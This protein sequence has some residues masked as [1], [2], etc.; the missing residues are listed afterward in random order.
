MKKI[1]VLSMVLLLFASC[2]TH[3]V[4]GP[5]DLNNGL[6][7]DPEI[8]TGVL[9]NGLRYVIRENKNPEQ[10][11]EF[12]FG[13]NSGSLMEEDDEKGIAHFIEHMAFNGTR[14]FSQKEMFDFFQ[15]NGMSF[16][17]DF[18]A[19]TTHTRIVYKFPLP[20]DQKKTID[21]G[22]L[23]LKDWADGIRFEK[24]EVD[25]ERNIILEELRARKN[26]NQRIMD[27][28]MP[29]VYGV[30]YLKS[31]PIG[32]ESVIKTV[33]HQKLK[34][35]YKK[36]YQ[37]QRMVVVVVGDINA[38]V[39]E[40]RIKSTFSGLKNN[41]DLPGL[42]DFDVPEYDTFQY[43]T[44]SDP[45]LTE[46][47]IRIYQHINTRKLFTE[48]DLRQYLIEQIYS[49]ILKN[50][51]LDKSLSNSSYERILYSQDWLKKYDGVFYLAATVKDNQFKACFE[52]IF[53]EYERM[54]RY[55]VF[56]SEVKEAKKNLLDSSKTGDIEQ[57]TKKSE[58]F[59]NQYVSK[60]MDESIMF[61]PKEYIRLCKKYL[62]SIKD[63]D[64][65][66]FLNRIDPNNR[67]IVCQGNNLFINFFPNKKDMDALFAKVSSM[68]V[69]LYSHQRAKEGLP[70]QQL[71]KSKIVN[72]KYYEK[73]NVTRLE[74][75]NGAKVVLKPTLFKQDDVVFR[76]YSP[77]CL[78][79]LDLK[80]LPLMELADPIFKQ[81]GLG[82]L[83]KLELYS[84]L[85][86]KKV[87][88]SIYVDIHEE[89]ISGYFS[90]ANLEFFF[91]LI[92]LGL[93]QPRVE[94]SAFE[95]QKLKYIQ[96]KQKM[97]NTAFWKFREKILQTAWP[98]N[99]YNHIIGAE[100]IQKLEFISSKQ[101][102]KDRFQNAGDFTFQFVG[103]FKMHDIL[104]LI[105]KHL[106]GLP[107]DKIK[108]K[109]KNINCKPLPGKFSISMNENIEEKSNIFIF[110]NHYYT[111][112][113][114]KLFEFSALE[115]ILNMKINESLREDQSLIYTSKAWSRF[116][117]LKPSPHCVIGF[118][119][120]CAPENAEKVVSGVKTIL[121]DLRENR[122]SEEKIT[123]IKRIQATK[124]REARQDNNWW[125]SAL[126]DS[127]ML[128]QD[129]NDLM[130]YENYIQELT[131]DTLQSNAKKYLD[132]ANMLVAVLNPKK[133]E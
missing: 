109:A 15:K 31:R 55:G 40:A 74:L 10:K 121:K 106:A 11:A 117:S 90:P 114:K 100:S 116:F 93:S 56:E 84:K 72:T 129:L 13:I 33:S 96:K 120:T 92:S 14:H 105:E 28:I 2:A 53:L 16:G 112:S 57:K 87:N 54:K 36:W 4:Y 39:I 42:K 81:S 118:V 19:Y 131:P 26:L 104:P 37:P 62:P 64:I 110:L 89:G 12:R 23:I 43:A 122:M 97:Q 73:I 24:Q 38:D 6:V 108:E 66:L 35:C 103:N 47:S 65:N 49:A 45:E 132:E 1:I 115:T 44:V 119:F 22:F 123:Q 99:A 113:E 133:D 79:L 51:L 20:S 102:L 27:K 59:A 75:S 128:N 52:E 68:E 3:L 61:S 48:R 21:K 50:R 125:S 76:A 85:K 91:K 78:S 98:E 18:N 58:T 94:K 29:L 9:E 70:M 30:S 25:K 88:A 77:G 67:V 41:K 107:A 71:T 17:A 101:A 111:V 86:S 8:R 130:E 32:L 7:N 69:G 127:V 5:K 46:S 60:S 83:T 34:A 95:E 126:K 63:D 82:P 80:F 124:A